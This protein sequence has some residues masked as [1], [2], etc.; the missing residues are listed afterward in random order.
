MQ[1]TQRLKEIIRIL[2]KYGLR[3]LEN[4]IKKESKTFLLDEQQILQLFSELGPTFIKFGQFLSTRPDLVDEK[5]VAVLRN[6]QDNVPSVPFTD[7]KKFIEETLHENYFNQFREI[8]PI[9]LASASIAQVYRGTLLNGQKVVLKI[10]RPI[11]EK[12]IATDLEIIKKYFLPQFKVLGFISPLD[13]EKI[14]NLFELKL[15]E[16]LDFLHELQNIRIFYNALKAEEDILIPKA[17][18][19]LSGRNILVME[20]IEGNQLTNFLKNRVY[21]PALGEKL[22]K[23]FCRMLLI[24]N[25]FHAD[26]H[27]GNIILTKDKKI[28]FVDFGA[29][30]FIDN[31]TRDIL[32]EL[33][34]YLSEKNFNGIINLIYRLGQHRGEIDDFTFYQEIYKII[35]LVSEIGKGEVLAGRIILDIIKISIKYGINVPA[36]LVY[37]GKAALNIESTAFSLGTRFNFLDLAK[38]Y[39]EQALSKNYF[40]YLEPQAIYLNLYKKLEV[41]EKIPLLL[42]SILKKFDEGNSQVV[43]KHAGLESII[44]ALDRTSMRITFGLIIASLLIASGLIVAADGQLLQTLGTT[45]YLL[46][47]GAALSLMYLILKSGKWH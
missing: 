34:L 36:N 28:G 8:E 23:S 9:P 39:S 5:L 14:Y 30:G 33:F 6:L 20:Y 18:K 47:I 26:P 15:K 35:E 43:F 2:G 7:C 32:S 17:F 41:S 19:D 42:L 16:E 37:I 25:L 4:K 1:E 31:K 11:L 13:L 27:P 12:I 38:E 46:S 24:E 22:V 21:Y 29:V 10:K 40:K 45:T 3:I 44:K